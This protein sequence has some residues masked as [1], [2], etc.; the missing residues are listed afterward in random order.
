[1]YFLH[2]LMFALV[3]RFVFQLRLHS[4]LGFTIVILYRFYRLFASILGSLF[5]Y[6]GVL[7]CGFPW[8]QGVPGA[9]WPP[10]RILVQKVK[11]WGASWVRLGG[12]DE[13]Q[14]FTFMLKNNLRR[15]PGGS[16]R[17]FLRVL[18]TLCNIEASKDRFFDNFGRIWGAAREAKLCFR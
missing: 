5:V 10:S 7:F 6:F 4:I 18:K 14:N 17:G 13:G 3:Q 11:F 16:G 8:S 15:P 2:C 9:S 1:M 12:Q